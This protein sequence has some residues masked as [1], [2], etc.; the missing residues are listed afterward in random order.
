MAILFVLRSAATDIYRR[1]MDAVEPELVDAAEAS[2]RSTQGVLDV[3]DLRLRWTG[4]KIRAETGIVVDAALGIV[5]A[6][7]IA[8]EAHHRL[9]HDVPKLL[10]VTVHVNPTH[11]GADRHHDALAH[12]LAGRSHT[13]T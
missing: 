3:E 2:L 4:H 12:H 5:E 9:L 1:L 7:A 11:N 6:H 13:H 10:D 8:V